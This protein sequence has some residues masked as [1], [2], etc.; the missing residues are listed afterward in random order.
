MQ[1]SAVGLD[2]QIDIESGEPPERVRQLVKMGE[3]TCY[4]HRAV[5]GSMPVHTSVRLNGEE[6]QL[7]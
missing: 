7:D 5:V 4:T 2:L 3:Q 1:A 6:L